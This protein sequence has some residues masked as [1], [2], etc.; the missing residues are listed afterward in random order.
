MA[1]YLFG[2]K[3]VPK[4]TQATGLSSDPKK[5]CESYT[6]C[7]LWK[8]LHCIHIYNRYVYKLELGSSSLA[9]L[10]W[11]RMDTGYPSVEPIYAVGSACSFFLRGG[12]VGWFTMYGPFGTTS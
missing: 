6:S 2:R 3:W 12:G 1:I 11:F 4:I 7:H 10:G 9:L 8:L 5:D